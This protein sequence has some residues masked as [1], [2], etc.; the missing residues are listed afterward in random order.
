MPLSAAA[1]H[2]GRAWVRL[3]G[4]QPSVQAARE[5]IGGERVEDIEARVWWDGVRHCQQPLLLSDILW[6]LSVPA[7]TPPLPLP[8]DPL[9]DWGGAV[10]WYAGDMD[11]MTVRKVAERAG[12]SALCWRGPAPLG[13]FHP[14]SSSVMEI[15]KRLKARFDPHGIFNPGRLIAELR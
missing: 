10:R 7:T 12:G 14:L 9:M 4:A 2:E 11:E 1:W 5:R 15:H 13:R 6:R 8:G 3:S